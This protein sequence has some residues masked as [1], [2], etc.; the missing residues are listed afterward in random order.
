MKHQTLK[1]KF[2]TQDQRTQIPLPQARPTATPL[3]PTKS[4]RCSTRVR[5]ALNRHAT[6]TRCWERNATTYARKAPLTI[7]T[8]LAQTPDVMFSEV[9]SNAFRGQPMIKGRNGPTLILRYSGPTHIV[10]IDS[11]TP[12]NYQVVCPQNVDEESHRGQNSQQRLQ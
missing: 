8:R 4:T 3:H 7:D 12:L 6:N 2:A 11:L 10:S 5:Q 1:I 9:N